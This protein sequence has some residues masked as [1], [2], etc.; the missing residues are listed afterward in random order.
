MII[1]I[2]SHLIPGVDDGAQTLAESIKL[3]KLGYQEGVRHIVLTPHHRNGQFVNRKKDVLKYAEDLNLAYQK[4]RI[5]IQVYP[6]QE[7]RLTEDFLE[8]YFS[9][10]LLSLDAAGRYY[11]IEFP[12]LKLPTFT[13]QLIDQLVSMGLTPVI[14]HPERNHELAENYDRLY[15]LVEKGCLSQ[16]TSSSYI[17]LYGSKLQ[18]AGRDMIRLNLAHV[19]ASDVHHIEYRPF[20]MKKAFQ[21]LESEF[22]EAHVAYFKNNAKDILNGDPVQ[23]KSPIQQHTKKKK[24]RFFGLF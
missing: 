8:D 23:A 20:N 21:Q 17:G 2:H 6:S 13:D 18:E 1:D 14:A 11:L 3:A 4:A 12:T 15:E 7:I 5:P 10:Q 9:D 19:I 22:G 16:I 24:K